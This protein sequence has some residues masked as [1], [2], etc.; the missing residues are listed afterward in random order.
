[1]DLTIVAVYTICDD[2]LISRGHQDDPRAKMSDAEVMTTALIA[3]RYFAG[4]QQTACAVLKTLGYIPNMLGHSRF[5]RRL[6]QIAEHFQTLFQVLAEGFKAEN[7][8]NIFSIDTFPVAV[9]D[10]IRISRSQVYQGPDWRGRISS[11]RRYF[12]GLKAHLMVTETGKIVEAFFTP[13]RCSDVLGLRCYSFD[14]PQGSVVYA[15]KAYC[16]Y[17]IEDALAASGISLKPIR[18]KNAKRQYPP[19]EVYLQHFHRKQVEV[20]NSLIEQLFPK[21]IHAVTAKGFELKVFLF[22]IATSIKQLFAD[23]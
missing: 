22:I 13:G 15:D 14:L 21:S 23:K 2:L 18:K 17:G 20:T 9:C 8:E 11:K 3:A 4:N 10:N 5:N 7:S 12:Y 19:H 6:H 16:N 1:M